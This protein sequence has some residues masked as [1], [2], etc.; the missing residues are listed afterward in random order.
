MTIHF[1]LRV[2]SEG[3]EYIFRTHKDLYSFYYAVDP[4][5]LTAFSRPFWQMKI[6]LVNLVH[7]PERYTIVTCDTFNLIKPLTEHA[8]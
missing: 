2:Q 6:N 3:H 7:S 1:P 8:V 5:F 4:S